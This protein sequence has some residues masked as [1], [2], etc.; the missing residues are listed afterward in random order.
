MSTLLGTAILDYGDNQRVASPSGNRPTHRIVTAHRAY[1]CKGEDRWCAIA[2]FTEG[3]W[4]AF[5][6]VL[7]YPS[8]TREE[9]FATPLDRWRNMGQL[10]SLVEE[11]TKEHSAEEVMSLLREAVVAA[12][13]VQ[14]TADLWQNPQLK[15]WSFFVELD[16]PVLGKVSFNV[17]PIQLSHTPSHFQQAAPS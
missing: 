4:Q 2:V 16:H 17:S 8:W 6:Q 10:D 9:R 15:A 7:G 12:G 5:C 13:V 11:W 14:D 1:C 3:E